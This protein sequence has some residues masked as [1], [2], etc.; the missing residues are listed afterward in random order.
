MTSNFYFALPNVCQPKL[1]SMASQIQQSYRPKMNV[2][3]NVEQIILEFSLP[4]VFK[5]DVKMSIKDRVLFL[6]ADRKSAYDEKNYHYR[7][8]NAVHFKS[9][10]Q[11]P[12]D[13]VTD[14]VLAQFQNGVLRITIKKEKK[15]I[16]QVEIK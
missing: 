16:I 8:F 13:V 10:I 9:R 6:E 12:E 15:P 7:E 5:E 14:S 1:K 3:Q 2:Q 11:L 4:G